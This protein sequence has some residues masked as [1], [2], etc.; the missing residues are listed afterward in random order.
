MKDS[1]NKKN[2]D[3]NRLFKQKKKNGLLLI[4]TYNNYIRRSSQKRYQAKKKSSTKK[5]KSNLHKDKKVSLNDL[6][7]PDDIIITNADDYIRKAKRLLNDPR[8]YKVLAKDLTT[9]NNGLI[10]QAIDR[11]TKEQLINENIANGLKNQ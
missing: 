7:K 5:I 1:P 9:T 3:E 10:N 6:S 4:T 11:F 8:N 2:D